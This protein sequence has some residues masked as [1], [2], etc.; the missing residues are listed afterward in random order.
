MYSVD[1]FSVLDCQYSMM[2]SACHMNMH[3]YSSCLSTSRSLAGSWSAF[4]DPERF[5]FNCSKSRVT[6]F[7]R[8]PCIPAPTRHLGTLNIGNTRISSIINPKPRLYIYKQQWTALP[9]PSVLL[10]QR[11]LKRAFVRNTLRYTTW[12][13]RLY[14]CECFGGSC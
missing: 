3:A 11:L 9:T 8:V 10:S 12:L 5:L 2:L 1:C 14:G 4:S 6:S 13:L 7:T